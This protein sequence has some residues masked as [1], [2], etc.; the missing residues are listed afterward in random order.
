MVAGLWFLL[1]LRCRQNETILAIE[2]RLLL[3]LPVRWHLPSLT[4]AVPFVF[5]K[6]HAALAMAV[7]VKLIRN[8]NLLSHRDISFAC[9]LSLCFLCL[10]DFPDKA[11][12]TAF[13]TSSCPC[14]D[15][16]R[17]AVNAAVLDARSCC[18]CSWEARGEAGVDSDAWLMLTVEGEAA[19]AAA[20]TASTSTVLTSSCV[21]VAFAAMVMFS[22][23][24]EGASSAML[25][26][27]ER[28]CRRLS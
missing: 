5:E 7:A 24:G 20:A 4:E 28:D 3:P 27:G 11:A 2:V 1:G 17:A 21:G 18:C 19:A 26:S 8:M 16:K 12:A 22:V 25:C 6:H 10:P 13:D 23:D 9:S 15:C 14:A